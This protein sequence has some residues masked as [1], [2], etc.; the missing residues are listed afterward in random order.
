[1]EGKKGS[2]QMLICMHTF[3]R[4]H[5]S[6]FLCLGVLLPAAAPCLLLLATTITLIAVYT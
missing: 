6:H 1:M 2:D 4:F 5:S 3:K